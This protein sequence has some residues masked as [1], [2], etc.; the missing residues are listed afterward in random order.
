MLIAWAIEGQL[1]FIPFNL[2]PFKGVCKQNPCFIDIQAAKLKEID[3]GE[4]MKK[5]LGKTRETMRNYWR[6]TMESARVKMP[7]GA[8]YVDKIISWARGDNWRGKKNHKK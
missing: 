7:R 4:T 6:Q 2:G 5:M 1:I 3:K 8:Q